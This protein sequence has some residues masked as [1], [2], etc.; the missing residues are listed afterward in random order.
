M[1]ITHTV[2]VIL[3]LGLQCVYADSES[4]AYETISQNLLPSELFTNLYDKEGRIVNGQNAAKNQ[5]PHQ[6]VLTITTSQGRALCGGSLIAPL[7][8][9]SAAHCIIK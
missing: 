1:A 3:C 9:L 2:L 5:F 6:A 4:E 7:W 8:I